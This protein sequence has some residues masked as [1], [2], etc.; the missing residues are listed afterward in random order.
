MIRAIKKLEILKGLG[1]FIPCCMFDIENRTLKCKMWEVIYDEVGEIGFFAMDKEV[2][3][4]Q[5]VFLPKKYARKIG[6]ST[7][8]T[9]DKLEKTLLIGCLHIKKDH[10]GKGFATEL[11]QGLIDFC[12][13]K[14]FD[15][16]E[17]AVNQS[18][19]G[20][21]MFEDVS[22]FPFKKFGFKVEEHCPGYEFNTEIKMCYCNIGED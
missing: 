18:P 6:L 17:V 8:P 10:R 22:L 7:C 13:T 12:K 21:N 15:R 3:T 5:M 19:P 11:I 14:E 4:G 20:D 1:H 16:I 9:N 2:F